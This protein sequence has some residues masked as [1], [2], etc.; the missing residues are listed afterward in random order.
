MDIHRVLLGL[1]PP[2]SIP[3]PVLLVRRRPVRA[4]PSRWLPARMRPGIRS[5]GVPPMR[6]HAQF[7]PVSVRPRLLTPSIAHAPAV[8][9]PF[10]LVLAG[11]L[12]ADAVQWFLHVHELVLAEPGVVLPRCVLRLR[13]VGPSG[14]GVAQPAAVGEGDC[15]ANYRK[16]GKRLVK[17]AGRKAKESEAERDE[18]KAEAHDPRNSPSPARPASWASIPSGMPRLPLAPP[19]GNTPPRPRRSRAR[20]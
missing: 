20:R 5:R 15:I 3:A 18:R 17:A 11:F 9:A 14:V 2:L 13:K 6:P 19:R 12:L 16:R 1:W 4:H 8:L 7:R 10:V